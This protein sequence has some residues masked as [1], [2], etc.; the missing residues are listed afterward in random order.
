MVSLLSPAWLDAVARAAAGAR[1]GAQQVGPAPG[2]SGAGPAVTEASH[3]TVVQVV[4]TEGKAPDILWWWVCGGARPEVGEGKV[5]DPVVTVTVDRSDLRRL[6]TG[7]LRLDVGYMQGQVKVDGPIA[8][9]LAVLSWSA[10][11]ESAAVLRSVAEVTD[12]G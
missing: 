3:P 2:G 11:V 1:C 10:S 9:V 4:V 6:I 7:D 5:A 12:D 8:A